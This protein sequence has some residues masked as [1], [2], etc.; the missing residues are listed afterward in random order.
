MLVGTLTPEQRAQLIGLLRIPA[1]KEG[2]AA[3]TA[4]GELYNA[5]IAFKEPEE[6][7]VEDVKPEQ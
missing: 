3:Y 6:D 2:P 4:L 5:L 7:P 1:D